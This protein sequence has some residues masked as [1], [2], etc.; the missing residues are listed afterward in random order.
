MPRAEFWQ[1][2]KAIAMGGI[3]AGCSFFG[4]Y[5]ITP[6]TEIAEVM[7]EELPR[8]D[9][10]FIQMEDEI[11][12]IAATIG[13]SISGRKAMT[14]TSG[15]GFSLKQ[16][17][18]GYAYIAEIP[19]VCVDVQRGGPSTG[20]PTKVSQGDVMQARWGTHGDHA[21]I[22]YAPS[23]VQECYDLTVKAF[24]MSERF[25]QP[26]LIMTDEVV[27][28]MRERI[29][30]PD[31]GS[32]TLVDRKKPTCGPAEFI[33]YLADADDDIPPMAAF[34]DGYHWHITGLTTNDWGFPTNNAQDIEKKNLRLL[35]K[36]DRF[37]SD[38]V[39]YEAES[40]EDADILVVSYGCVARSAL[41]AVREL[42]GRGV[43]VGHF[44]P[45]TLW[46]FADV[47]LEKI[48]VESGIK[49]VIVP[50]LNMGQMF[51]EVDRAVHGKAATHSKTLLNGELFK[52]A[53]IM[54][55]IEEVA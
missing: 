25:R 37:R 16:E 53:Q 12:G 44:R 32:L 46:P 38:V 29:F 28:H 43:K 27:G 19:M 36:V 31:K 22:A 14:G 45:I 8:N 2:N 11:A 42:R 50:E 30:V 10:K 1:G 20:L 51:L 39:E 47:E 26:V 21:T 34:G 13:G 6:S 55:Y 40:Y 48:I 17:L 15:P 49:H 24:N 35:R 23:S 33:P 4:G 9:G 3:D 5:P 54:S 41:R 52:P 18:L 7:S